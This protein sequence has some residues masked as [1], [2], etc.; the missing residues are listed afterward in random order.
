MAKG[1]RPA[2]FAPTTTADSPSSRCSSPSSSCSSGCSASLARRAPPTAA[3]AEARGSPNGVQTRYKPPASA[4]VNPSVSRRRALADQSGFTLVEVMVAVLI[5]L[6]GVLGAL[7][8]LDGA[9]AATSRTKT[10]EAATN[11]ARELI[12]SARAVPYP[13]L[14]PR[15]R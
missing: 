11:L 8:L 4:A 3:A 13:R 10:R 5:L 1:C 6:A 12:E 14:S 15:P 9:N 2:D 7:T